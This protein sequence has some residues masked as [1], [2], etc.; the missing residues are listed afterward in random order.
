MKIKKETYIVLTSLLGSFLA[1]TKTFESAFVFGLLFF[2]IAF[3]SCI[4]LKKLKM[5]KEGIWTLLVPAFITIL[6][7]IWLNDALP[8]FYESYAVY[9][10]LSFLSVSLIYMEVDD[11]LDHKAWMKKIAMLCLTILL[12]FS[13]F[14]LI[15]DVLGT[16]TIHI[17]DEI[18]YITGYIEIIEL[19]QFKYFPLHFFESASGVFF[20]AALLWII[21]RPSKEE[22]K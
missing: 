10:G 3:L 2:I 4:I 13:M 16:G 1:V 11:T 17:M 9:Y 7:L 19:P 15:R 22:T 18:R 6:S 20:M 12:F 21:L 8:N 14:G 5:K